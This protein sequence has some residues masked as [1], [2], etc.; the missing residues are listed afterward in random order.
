M[1]IEL[2]DRDDCVSGLEAAVRGLRE[3]RGGQVVALEGPPGSGKTEM[4]RYLV[5][6]AEAGHADAAGE[7]SEVRVLRATC[8]PAEQALPMGVVKQLAHAVAAPAV[9]EDLRRWIERGVR[10]PAPGTP[11]E[12][13]QRERAEAFEGVCQALLRLAVATPLVVAIEDVEHIDAPSLDCLLVLVRRLE[14]YPVLV[15]VTDGASRH[16]GPS[17]FHVEALQYRNLRRSILGPL[18]PAGIERLAAGR[19]GAEEA[20]ALVPQLVAYSGGNA[21]L[22]QALIDDHVL[23]G[24]PRLHGYGLGVVACLR[25]SAPVLRDVAEAVAV[26]AGDVDLSLS[27]VPQL[28]DADRELVERSRQA[29]QEA[30]VLGE[31][32][33]RHPTGAAA[34]LEILSSTRMAELRCRAAEMLHKRGAPATAI[35]RHLVHT[36]KECAVPVLV[37][38]AEQALAEEQREP[39]IAY[40][41]RALQSTRD[42]RP[43]ETSIRSLLARAEWLVNPASSARH[44]P[45][46]VT[47]MEAL[48]LPARLDL[49][50]QLLW[51]GRQDAAEGVLDRA[52]RAGPA[53]GDEQA[54]EQADELADL[55]VWLASSYPRMV[56]GR[57]VDL[58]SVPNPPGP[59][60]VTTDPWLRSAAWLADALARGRSHDTV[61]CAEQVLGRLQFRTSSP[62]APEVVTAALLVLA[63]S[64]HTD[65]ALR[66]CEQLVQ[67]PGTGGLPT[68]QAIVLA[69]WAEAALRQG[70]LTEAA[71]LARRALQTLPAKSW[72]VG[73]GL[74]LGTLVLASTRMGAHEQA[75][76]DLGLV[77]PDA[78]LDCRYGLHYLHARGHHHLATGHVHAALADF[79]ACGDLM[80]DWGLDLNAL[81]PW[82]LGAAEAWAQLGHHDQAAELCYE[83]LNRSAHVSSRTRGLALRTLAGSSPRKRRVTL[84]SEA[85]DLFEDCGDRYEQTR[86]LAA[87]SRAYRDLGDKRRARAV[88]R[89]ALHLADWC[90][91]TST[92]QELLAAM[93]SEMGELGGSDAAAG[94]AELSAA[95]RRVASLAVIGYTNREIADKLFI[96]PSTV[97]QHLTRVYRKLKVKGRHDL[98]AVWPA[99]G[100]ARSDAG[101]E[102]S[103]MASSVS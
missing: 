62:W 39:A 102:A 85:L 29:L 3:G 68:W 32:G 27:D 23:H 34:V 2:V 9:A 86:V 41:E 61:D 72:G 92:R 12:E 48:D 20:R 28:I 97:E 76:A 81:V 63:A 89:R 60:Q 77:V 47:G 33:F 75:A 8:S 26:L 24:E 15:A 90:G 54:C 80:R 17:A 55:D 30:G 59:I 36:R 87:L 4:L 83:E 57:R 56:R 50:R 95:E 11:I 49:V 70:A 43:G 40:L 82:R 5:Q 73:L 18:S 22:V 19:L 45:S 38:A 74:P 88:Y 51:H 79:V 21:A 98:P 84:L 1:S 93:G 58:S 96:T 101:R 91:A 10:Q 100:R 6:R 42:D 14:P 16:L 25:K 99:G 103:R 13:V 53:A 35:A 66:C 64:D 67:L 65:A 71:C 37:E 31:A 44:H 69:G 7:A 46:L 94:M 52:R 78:L